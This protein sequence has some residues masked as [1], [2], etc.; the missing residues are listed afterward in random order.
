MRLSESIRHRLRPSAAAGRI[1]TVLGVR[2]IGGGCLRY[3]AYEAFSPFSESVNTGGITV[4]M[5]FIVPR[6]WLCF[7]AFLFFL[8]RRL[9]R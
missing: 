9:K 4:I 8:E 3:R 7:G 6:Q 5:H 2:L 1:G